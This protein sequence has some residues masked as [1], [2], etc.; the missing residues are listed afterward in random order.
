MAELTR[1][2]NHLF[3]I[4]THALDIGAM[5][6]L[7]WVFEEREKLYEIFERV[8]G[9]RMHSAYIRPGGVDRDLPLGLL[10]DIYKWTQTCTLVLG[11]VDDLLTENRVWKQRTVDIGVI[12]A[13]EA[14][15][16]GFSGVML[17]G[18]GIKWDLRKA[19][20]YDGYEKVDFDVPVGKKGDSYDRYL[21]RLEEIRQSLRIVDQCL[22]KMPAGEI[23]VDDY[24]VAPPKRS[25]M[26]S[27]MEAL[28]HH[29]KLYSEGYQVPPGATY[30]AIEAPK[31]EFGVYLVSDGS[32]R[33]YR[34]KIKA[35]G[36]AHL[37]GMN[38]LAKG[39]MLADV[40]AIVGTIDVVFGEV[41]R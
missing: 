8:S 7:F 16:Y 41:D 35:P 39:H 17:R 10:D 23:K 22:N 27:S 30:S 33:P 31:G 5:T 37:S 19:Q 26:K 34:C 25:H 15:N 36:F 28:I 20:P 29:F 32:S 2:T 3:G 24:K 38:R 12:T 18:S 13:E 4:V 40:V 6:P 9:A 1:I 14:L 11:E 21:C